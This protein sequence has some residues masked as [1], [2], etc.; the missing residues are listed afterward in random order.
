[1]LCGELD[2][3]YTYKC[4]KSS[5]ALHRLLNVFVWWL[6]SRGERA[7][8]T[9]WYNASTNNCLLLLV[10]QGKHFMEMDVHEGQRC[11]KATGKISFLGPPTY[12]LRT[13]PAS[14]RAAVIRLCFVCGDA[15][16]QSKRELL[17]GKK[18]STSEPS[19]SWVFGK[20]SAFYPRTNSRDLTVPFQ[21][22]HNL[23]LT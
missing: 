1:M 12:Q 22:G 18:P 8:G 2:Q 7:K 14:P 3:K 9:C 5:W 15:D 20:C 23:A 10:P 4:F 6:L 16:V 21:N 19:Q 17:K 13:L 11:K